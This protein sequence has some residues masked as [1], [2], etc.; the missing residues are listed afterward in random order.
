MSGAGLFYYTLLKHQLDQL[1]RQEEVTDN[2]Q[3]ATNNDQPPLMPQGQSEAVNN[4]AQAP[5]G[6]TTPNEKIAQ[7]QQQGMVAQPQRTPAIYL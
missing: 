2:V 1:S 6:I 3:Q 4:Q 7:P 5:S